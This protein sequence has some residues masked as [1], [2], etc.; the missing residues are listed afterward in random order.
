VIGR[1]LLTSGSQTRMQNWPKAV[2]DADM[3]ITI[4][5]D[6]GKGYGRKGAALHGMGDLEGAHKAYKA[7]L[8]IEPGVLSCSATPEQPN[9]FERFVRCVLS[10][11]MHVRRMPVHHVF[12]HITVSKRREGESCPVLLLLK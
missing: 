3:C 7:G 11:H 8:A 4:K 6:W 2:Q 1:D 9:L 10:A 5:P 12:A